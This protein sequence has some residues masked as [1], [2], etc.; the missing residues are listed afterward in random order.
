MSTPIVPLVVLVGI[1]GSGKSTIA[2]RWQ[3]QAPS[4]IVVSTDTIRAQLFGDATTQGPWPA[5][6]REVCDRWQRGIHQI[7]TGQTQ[8][9][10]YDATHAKRRDRRRTLQTARALGFTTID[11]Y[12]LDL[13]LEVCLERNQRRSRQVPVAVIHQMHQQLQRHPP[14][15]TDG[16]NRLYTL[17]PSEDALNDL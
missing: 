2:Q 9:V 8:A 1:P 10:L 5:I 14:H 17:A 16:F 6:W 12:W 7:K 15:L 13:P 3:S 11:G 4:R